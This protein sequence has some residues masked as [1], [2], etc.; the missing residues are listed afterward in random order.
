MEGQVSIKKGQHPIVLIYFLMHCSYAFFSNFKKCGEYTFLGGV[1][2]IIDTLHIAFQE[3]NNKY[4]IVRFV[5][6]NG[7]YTAHRAV[8]RS[9]SSY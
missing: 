9:V 4:D 3:K 1:G 7:H 8:V 2:Q 6:K 5:D